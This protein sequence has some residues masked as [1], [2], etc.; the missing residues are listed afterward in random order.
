ML[1]SLPGVQA[2][3][4]AV[5][6]QWSAGRRNF[7]GMIVSWAKRHCKLGPNMGQRPMHEQWSFF[8]MNVITYWFC[9]TGSAGQITLDYV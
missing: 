1:G 3:P 9:D 2:T 8:D 5:A 7:A 6:A 4:V